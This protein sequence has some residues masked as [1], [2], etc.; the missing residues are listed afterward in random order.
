[1]NISVSLIRSMTRDEREGN[2]LLAVEKPLHEI[3]G[4]AIGYLPEDIAMGRGADVHRHIT[5]MHQ[6]LNIFCGK[7]AARVAVEDASVWRARQSLCLMA[8]LSMQ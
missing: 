7:Q 4:R 6:F 8:S 3:S 5:E 2:Q 1:M